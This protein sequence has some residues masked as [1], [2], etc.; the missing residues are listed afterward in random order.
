MQ[1]KIA[2]TFLL[3]A[4]LICTGH[5]SFAQNDEEALLSQLEKDDQTA[6]DAI[7]M[8]PSQTRVNIFEASKFP[9]IVVRLDAMQ[10]KT[11]L[12]FTQLLASLSKE[13]QEKIWD[14]TRYPALIADIALGSRKSEA[15][16][17]VLLPNYPAVIRQTAL[18]EGL[19][20]Y[21][22]LHQITVKN[23]HHQ[24]NF[25]KILSSYPPV[26]ANAYRDLIKRPEILNTLNDNMQMTV[27]IGDL[28]KR[29]PRWV[30]YKTDSLNKALT[31][32]NA[33]DAADWQQSMAD[34]PQAQ[35]EFT[36]AAAEYA[37]DNNYQTDDYSSPMT[38]DVTDYSTY[39]YDWWFGY[40]TWYPYAYWDPYPFWYDWGFYFGIGGRPVFF[41]MP[42]AH[43]MNW[44]FY[45]PEHWSHYPGFGNHCY[46]YYGKHKDAQYRNNISRSVHE[47]KTRNSSVV[48]G[49]WDKDKAGRTQRFKD[50]GKSET[51][52]EKQNAGNPRLAQVSNPRVKIPERLYTTP[53]TSAVAKPVAIKRPSE[54]GQPAKT[55]QTK[56][57]EPERKT[58]AVNNPPANQ[59]HANTKQD[60]SAME[61]HQNNWQQAQQQQH[62]SAPQQHYSAPAPAPSGG[63]GRGGRR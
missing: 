24:D 36:Q 34:D 29:D 45:N 15:E 28:Y 55:E 57:P 32:Q 23:V 5:K 3:S 43:F 1:K 12:K 30:L 8:Y 40:P 38:S 4:L 51:I 37:Q 2:F 50:F 41:G 39:S 49:D 9:E 54:T 61:Y 14:L 59:P 52:K 26:T 35:Q 11:Q 63:G 48:N 18:D 20:N 42:S 44:Y 22:L 17:N 27:L 19:N 47:W 25:E 46:D 58:Q 53:R 56:A 31:A 13:E 60:R 33:Q 21:D 16:I 62:Y 7:A 6:I 10:K